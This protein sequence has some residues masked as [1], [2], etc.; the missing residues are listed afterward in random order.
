MDVVCKACLA[1]HL[2]LKHTRPK[3]K[4][5]RRKSFDTT[6]NDEPEELQFLSPFGSPDSELEYADTD[7]LQFV[8]S[9]EAA[10][11]EDD[12]G[13]L[14]DDDAEDDVED[15]ELLMKTTARQSCIEEAVQYKELCK[16]QG[17]V[18][19]WA[20]KE[21]H[22][23]QEMRREIYDYENCSIFAVSYA[24]TATVVVWTLCG[25]LLAIYLG[26]RSLQAGSSY[27]R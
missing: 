2:E 27:V 16:I 23:K 10:S 11:D 15:D 22:L 26:V 14:R 4:F 7:E 25:L 3:E 20:I 13:V 1:S 24:V 5:K 21:K 19:T 9:I 18:A 12:N 6:G 8:D 17:M